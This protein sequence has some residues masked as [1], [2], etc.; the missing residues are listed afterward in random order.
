MQVDPVGYKDQMNLYAY[1]GNDPVNRVDPS[2]LYECQGSRSHCAAVAALRQG[3]IAVSHS[4]RLTA[5]QR[6]QLQGLV[7]ML[8]RAGDGNGIT[9]KAGD[10]AGGVV[11]Q[12]DATEKGKGTITVDWDRMKSSGIGSLRKLVLR[13][14]EG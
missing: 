14:P 12:A 2:G 7:K 3:L 13:T 9:V 10:L 6:A 8:G 4:D 11:A 5:T 1:V